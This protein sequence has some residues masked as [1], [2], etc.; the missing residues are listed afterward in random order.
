MSP[1]EIL[2]YQPRLVTQGMPLLGVNTSWDTTT[3]GLNPPTFYGPFPPPPPPYPPFPPSVLL[4][5]INGL[6]TLGPAVTENPPDSLATITSDFI[7]F[8][9]INNSSYIIPEFNISATSQAQNGEISTAFNFLDI[10]VDNCVG[11]GGVS[12]EIV[13][14][15]SMSS[16][17]LGTPVIGSGN[18]DVNFSVIVSK[19]GTP[20]GSYSASVISDPFNVSDSFGPDIFTIT[21]ITINSGDVIFCRFATSTQSG[22]DA[23]NTSFSLSNVTVSITP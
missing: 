22:G 12:F 5:N 9:Q 6:N 2:N 7:P 11:I 21:G 15:V 13:G 14:T 16:A 20:V 8:T 4:F 1:K 17:Y 10:N 19:N 23:G 3:G 18:Y